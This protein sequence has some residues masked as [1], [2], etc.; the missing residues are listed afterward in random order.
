MG[1]FFK[2]S[3]MLHQQMPG[4]KPDDRSMESCTQV[5]IFQLYSNDTK[6]TNK[7]SKDSMSSHIAPLCDNNTDKHDSDS[8]NH[9]RNDSNE[10]SLH[11]YIQ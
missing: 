3:Q 4:A 6:N 10:S 8:K 1:S 7:H 9:N 2:T 5:S 11:M